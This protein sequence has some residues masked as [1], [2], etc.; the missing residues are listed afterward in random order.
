[1]GGF[2][3]FKSLL[4]WPAKL[5]NHSS[6]KAMLL[7]PN[8]REQEVGGQP[9][10]GAHPPGPASPSKDRTEGQQPVWSVA[11]DEACTILTLW[12]W[13]RTSGPVA[14]LCFLSPFPLAGCFIYHR[15]DL[16]HHPILCGCVLQLI[17]HW[18]PRS[19]AFPGGLEVMGY[20]WT[21]KVAPRALSSPKR[22]YRKTTFSFSHVKHFCV[23]CILYKYLAI[24]VLNIRAL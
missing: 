5:W 9:L 8:L 21:W 1:M 19:H 13:W 16:L 18:A 23:V 6:L 2:Y 3:C 15:W 10:K 24:F 17:G 7:I 22:D 14:A 20:E 12:I 4:P 11:W